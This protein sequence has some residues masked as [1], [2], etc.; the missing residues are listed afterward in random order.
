MSPTALPLLR[1]CQ[2]VPLDVHVDQRGKLSAL[3][4]TR[5]TGF[6]A[7]RIFL[8]SITDCETDTVRAEHSTSSAEIL[9]VL[10]GSVHVDLDNGAV[11]Q[12]VVLDASSPAFVIGAGVWRRLHSFAADSLILALAPQPYDQTESFSTPRPDLILG[13]NP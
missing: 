6:V 12:T 2:F 7:Q 10:A 9:L 1:G 4:L 5:V 8:I 13:T 11:Q 3:E